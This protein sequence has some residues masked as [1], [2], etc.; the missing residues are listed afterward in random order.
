MRPILSRHTRRTDSI[1]DDSTRVGALAGSGG[2]GPITK[3]ATTASQP[4]RGMSA[5]SRNLCAQ[6]GC[7]GR[8]QVTI[9][10]GP[11]YTA[12]NVLDGLQLCFGRVHVV[13]QVLRARPTRMGSASQAPILLGQVWMPSA[14]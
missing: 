8:P 2:P 3:V 7:E 6:C 9:D 14:V 4:G 10:P 5:T 13:G 1:L 11:G 12:I